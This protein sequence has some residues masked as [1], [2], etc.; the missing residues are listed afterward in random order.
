MAAI[1]DT[2]VKLI[3]G[4]PC[5]G[6]ST[7]I[8]NFQN[9]YV[10]WMRYSFRDHMKMLGNTTNMGKGSKQEVAWAEIMNLLTRCAY[11]VIDGLTCDDLESSI[12]SLNILGRLIAAKASVDMIVLNRS[13]PGC[14]QSN[15]LRSIRM[16]SSYLKECFINFKEIT[17]S[18][19]FKDMKD[20][21]KFSNYIE[22]PA[23]FSEKNKEILKKDLVL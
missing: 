21:R 15:Q 14:I 1:I 4:P 13:L 19:L 2:K 22:L 17:D 20:R 23:Q 9:E 5:S 3:W 6:K 11:V 12:F 8:R 10:Q 18:T 16:N 7:F